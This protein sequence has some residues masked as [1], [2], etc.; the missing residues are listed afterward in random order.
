[1]WKHLS[2]FFTGEY[3]KALK[4]D[5]RGRHVL[6]PDLA[7]L[8][9]GLLVVGP[10]AVLILYFVFLK[11]PEE[12]SIGVLLKILVTILCVLAG[13]WLLQLAANSLTT[14]SDSAPFCT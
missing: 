11:P 6:D 10:P 1:M 4:E 9:G 3:S 5:W 8:I 2:L 14:I 7:T 12:L 13:V